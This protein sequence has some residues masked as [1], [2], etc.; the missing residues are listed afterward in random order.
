MSLSSTPAEVR[1]AA[2]GVA[3]RAYL[4]PTA[5]GAWYAASL[6]KDESRRELLITLLRGACGFPISLDWFSR[7]TG[8][9]ERKAIAG[10]LFALQRE[11]LLTGEA[12]PLVPPSGPASRLLGGL[13]E[14]IARGGGIVLADTAGLCVA[15]AGTLPEM[16]EQLAARVASLDPRLRRL[17]TDGEGWSL[18][19]NGSD[20]RLSVRP[21]HLPSHRF[22]LVS[23]PSANLA[24]EDFVQFIG[25]LT[26]CCLGIITTPENEERITP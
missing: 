15:Y 6:G 2:E 25:V 12:V 9:R 10:L 24:G 26:R 21:L 18:G 1:P 7:W 16:A 14:Q 11:G 19:G 3:H 23:S 13:L 8:L 4:I 5:A 17:A 22:L 20:P